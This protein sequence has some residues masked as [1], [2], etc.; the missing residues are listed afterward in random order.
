[1]VLFGLK[2]HSKKFFLGYFY[3][4]TLPMQKNW[5]KRASKWVFIVY[6]GKL[7]KPPFLMSIP[8]APS[9][10]VKESFDFYQDWFCLNENVVSA[11]GLGGSVVN[12]P[13]VRILLGSPVVPKV[14]HPIL[15]SPQKEPHANHVTPPPPHPPAPTVTITEIEAEPG[16]RS[17]STKTCHKIP[18]VVPKKVKKKLDEY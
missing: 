2:T 5:A 7:W 15:H 17:F 8:E 18:I 12:H 14:P 4:P 16:C 6:R 10:R 3:P 11:V 13:P 1:M 9:C